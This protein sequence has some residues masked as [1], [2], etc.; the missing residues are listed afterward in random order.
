MRLLLYTLLIAL[1]STGSIAQSPD[2]LR[3][4]STSGPWIDTIDLDARSYAYQLVSDNV[5]K[6]STALRFEL[7]DGD[8]FTAYPAAPET[9]WDDCTRDRERTEVRE[10]YQAPIDT[11]IWYSIMLYIP[12]DYVP[13]YPKQIFM[14]WHS[15]AVGPN[16]YFHLN[17]NK[18]HV[19]ILA[20]PHMTTTQYTFGTDVLT[21]GTWHEITV[22]AIWSGRDDL[23]RMDLYVDGQRLVQHRGATLSPSVYEAGIGPNVKYGIYRS[24]LFRYEPEGPH[25]THVLYFDEYRR[26][27]DFSEVDPDR[28]EG[29]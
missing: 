22:N 18:F 1:L 28:Y 16:L 6:G 9:G 29:D 4:D 26:G 27:F 21:T 8:C 25:P 15:G 12:D 2:V 10:K 19:D 17:E 20:E 24:H 3:V 7:R 23:G 13:M 14:Q 5:G 11:D